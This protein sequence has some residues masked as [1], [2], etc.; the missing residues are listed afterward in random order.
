MLASF[1]QWLKV[2]GCQNMKLDISYPASGYQ[3]LNKVN[4][5]CKLCAFYEK[6]VAI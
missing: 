1:L 5:V 2:L 4:D 6:W 3:K